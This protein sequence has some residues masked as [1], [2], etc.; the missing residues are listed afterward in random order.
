MKLSVIIPCW[1][2]EKGVFRF[3]PELWPVLE[4]LGLDFEVVVVD[5]GSSDKTVEEVKKI[6]KPELRLVTYL[7]H[8]GLGAAVR[9][10]IAAATG[11]Y[12][13][14]LDSDFTFHP[15][16][17]PSLLVALNDNPQVD[18]IV[19]SANLAGYS[20]DIPAWRL[21]IS[22]AANLTYSIL[23]GRYVTA[24]SQ[25]FRLYK[26]KQLQELSLTSVGFDIDAE[27][28]FK[29][30]FRGKKFVEVPAKL[31]NRIYGVSKLNYYREIRRNLIL[32][33]KIL[34]WKFFGF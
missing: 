5:D 14:V 4:R 10:G 13:V 8:K 25:I 27:I 17:I 24:V 34:K 3:V 22:K 6:N 33:F 16:L 21:W 2:E 18:F 23:L 26:T 19:G 15:N 20:K 7:P 31:T 11:D 32:I 9:A 1:N 29:L 28:L 12:T 30:V